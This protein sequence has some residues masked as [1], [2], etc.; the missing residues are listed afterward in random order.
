MKSIMNAGWIVFV[1]FA[2]LACG[3]TDDGSQEPSSQTSAREESITLGDENLVLSVEIGADHTVDFHEIQSGD[4]VAVETMDPGAEPVVPAIADLTIREQY[5]RLKPGEAVPSVV[6]EAQERVEAFRAYL[7]TLPLDAS[8]AEGEG[9]GV[10]A[11]SGHGVRPQHSG[12]SG[13]HFT[14]ESCDETGNVFDVCYANWM[15]GFYAYSTSESSHYIVDSYDM[16]TD[17][18]YIMVNVTTPTDAGCIDYNYAQYQGRV[19]GYYGGCTGAYRLRRIDIT[20][21]T[22]DKFHVSGVWNNY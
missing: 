17:G 2:A 15:H 16:A 8:E 3:A 13:S 1:G 12:S 4:I 21:A 5:E 22:D 18:G 6:L 7:A 20:M 19:M 10:A 14:S 9:G 11:D